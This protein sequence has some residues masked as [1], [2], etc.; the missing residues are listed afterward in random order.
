MLIVIK[1][2]EVK[3]KPLERKIKQMGMH[4]LYT[5]KTEHF[6]F[7][8]ATK[9]PSQFQRMIQNCSEI[10]IPHHNFYLRIK[11]SAD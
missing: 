3:T 7:E 9:I 1:R 11:T 4:I 10:K 8:M 6:Q 2:I 5:N